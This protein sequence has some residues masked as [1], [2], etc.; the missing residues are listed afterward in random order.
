MVY[1]SDLQKWIW[2]DPTNNAYVMNEK[3]EL[4]SI[5]EVREKIINGQPL[6]LNPDANWNNKISA[7]K[8]DY[9]YTYMA[10]NLY[11]LECPVMSKYNYESFEKGETVTYIEL[12]PIDAY[13]QTPQKQEEISSHTGVKIINFKTNNPNIFWAKPE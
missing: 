10:K 8:E 13:N 7:V 1:S 6:I 2:I 12:L 3:G 9:L 4:L 11:R 5:R